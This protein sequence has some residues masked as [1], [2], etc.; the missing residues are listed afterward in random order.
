MSRARTRPAILVVDDDTYV[1][2]LVSRVLKPLGARLVVATNATEARDAAR[3]EPL[4]LAIVD[5]GLREGGGY[6]YTLAADLRDIQAQAGHQLT[7]IALTG[8]VPDS[9]SIAASG[10]AA[11]VMKPFQLAEFRAQVAGYLS[12][13][14]TDETQPE[15]APAR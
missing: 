3:S 7:V 6:G 11:T 15:D 13:A 9:A 14:A 8:Q 10:I 2:D 4:A 1:L 12:R 5:I